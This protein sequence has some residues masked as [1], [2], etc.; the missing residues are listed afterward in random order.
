MAVLS[1]QPGAVQSDASFD[2]GL[3]RDIR[4]W[5][6][7]ARCTI[8]LSQP[9][10]DPQLWSLY[11]LN[12]ERNYKR[13]GVESALD[14]DALRTGADTAMFMVILDEHNDMVGG[15]RAI[16]PLR[17]AD[18]SH[19]VLEWAGQPGEDAVAKMIT[20]R[21]PYGVLEMKSAWVGNGAC[22][23]R[24]VTD[25]LARSGSH[26]MALLGVQFCMATAAEYVLHRWRSSG[27][28]VAPIPPA[29]YPDHRYQTKMMWWDRA[30]Y[31]R[32]AQ[33][34]QVVKMMAEIAKFPT[35]L[36]ASAD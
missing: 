8:V 1:H 22:G 18:E 24:V 15:L 9:V 31:V 32:Y 19:A 29:A 5:D 10:L 11:G 4:W 7:D 21:V 28:V 13:H 30:T 33:P 16:G 27:G 36:R 34:A 26:M 20:D 6:A 14:T 12:A 35:L 17:S 25:A 2:I 23:S 3:D